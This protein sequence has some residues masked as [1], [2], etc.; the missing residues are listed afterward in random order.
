[1]I[2]E[3]TLDDVPS[4][5]GLGEVI[6]AA[7]TY[8]NTT[9]NPNAVSLKAVIMIRREFSTVLLAEHDGKPVGV[10]PAWISPS[11]FSNE[12]V[13]CEQVVYVSPEYRRYRHGIA[14]IKAYVAWAKRNNA[15]DIRIGNIGGM[16]DDDN[17]GRLLARLGFTRT[18]G[19][20][21]MR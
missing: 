16:T 13:A 5:I 20:Y 19:M 9:F 4:I 10:L 6:H 1:M 15:R 14:L 3:A 12:L 18:G 8:H 7:S 17:Y 11:F 21:V 2:R